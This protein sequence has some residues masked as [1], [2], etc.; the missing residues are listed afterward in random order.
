MNTLRGG[1]VI[2]YFSLYK[3][4]PAPYCQPEIVAEVTRKIWVCG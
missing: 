3:G 2:K 1:T 4:D